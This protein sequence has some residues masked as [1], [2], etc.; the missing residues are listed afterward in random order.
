M[1]EVEKKFQPTE[2][3]R[4]RLIDGAVFVGDKKIVDI[5]YDTSDYEFAKKSMWLRNRDNV[6]ELKVYFK[7]EGGD[8]ESAY[9]IEKE[10]EILE[11]LGYTEF[12]S[13]NEFANQKLNILGQIIIE[14][15]KYT[16]EGFNL[17]FD[18]IDFGLKKVYIEFMV[19]SESK[20]KETNEKIINFAKQF[21]MSSVDLPIKPAEYLRVVR[22]DIYNKIFKDIKNSEIKM[23]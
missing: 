20:V 18:E 11:K 3:Q 13:V 19:D 22:P 7:V 8:S 17:D 12:N 10:K 9:E 14:R 4:A 6:W 15:K 5:Y 21:D 1:I 16:K 23:K 2:E